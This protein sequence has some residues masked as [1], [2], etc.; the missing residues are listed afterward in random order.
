MLYKS[1]A[2]G[3][4]PIV[5]GCDRQLRPAVSTN[6]YK[7]TKSCLSSANCSGISYIQVANIRRYAC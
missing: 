1:F 6:K 7:E 2:G 5:E 3:A 4:Y